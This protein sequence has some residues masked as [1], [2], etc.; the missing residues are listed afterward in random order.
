MLT[1]LN[2]ILLV[3]LLLIACSGTLQAQAK[4]GDQ[5]SNTAGIKEPM[6]RAQVIYRKQCANCHGATAQGVLGEYDRPLIGDLAIGQLAELIDKTMPSD[7]P[8]ACVGED[9]KLVAEYIYNSFYSEAAQN[10]LHP[11]KQQFSRLTAEQFRQSLSDLYASSDWIPR[12]E[13]KRGLSA[14]YFRSAKHRK[15]DK[16]LERTDPVINF[17]FDRQSPGAGIEPKEFSINW[18]GGLLPDRSGQYEIIVRSSCSFTLQFGRH[19]RKLIDNHV[20][21]GDKTE[22]REQVFLTAGRVYPFRLNFFQRERKTELPPANISVSWVT[23]GGSEQIIPQENWVPG[24]MPAQFSVQTIFPADDRSYGFERGIKVDRDWDAAVTKSI[25]ELSQ[26]FAKE[27]WP[28]Y[29][30]KNKD[31]PNDNRQVLKSFLREKLNIAYRFQLN[32][33]MADLFVDK[34]VAKEEDN[35][36]AIKR[37]MLLGLKSPRFMYLSTDIEQSYSSRTGSRLALCLMDSLPVDDQLRKAMLAGQ[38]ENEEQIRNMARHLV[39]DYRSQAKMRSMI[40]EWLN[41]VSPRDRKKNAEIFPGF[42]AAVQQDSRRSLDAFVNSVLASDTCDFRQ[43]LTSDWGFTTKRM[44][45]YFGDSWA[46][47]EPFAEA[48]PAS[49]TEIAEARFEP[50]TRTAA[51]A[52]H[53]GLLTQPFLLSGLA[54]FDSSSPVHRGVFVFRNLLGRQIQPPAD[55]AFTPLGPDLHPDLTTRERVEL[56]TSP[57]SCDSCHNRINSLGFGLENWDATGRFRDIER[58]KPIDAKG[59]YTNRD[60]QQVEFEGAKKLAQVLVNSRDCQQAFVRRAFQHYAK[61]PPAAFAPDTLDRLTQRFIDSQFNIRELVIEIAVVASKPMP[62][63]KIAS[64]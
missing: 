24:W 30:K 9:A 2:R 35:A 26:V 60:G 63:E 34:Q 58:N 55:A 56:Q 49:E 38:L 18:N 11:P 19:D 62:P 46:P 8:S 21:S 22:F 40:Y 59:H 5:D 52:E 13:S 14:E 32:D 4:S 39:G 3:Y 53:S 20:Q 42:D 50:L 45:Q 25:V 15:E 33:S 1:S 48:K 16:V 6:E 44:Q 61:Q 51:R 31:Q 64:N 29:L 57:E 12:P 37:V 47:A 10:R 28:E 27:L 17:D 41:L 36:E 7:D 43:L 23:P 54:Y